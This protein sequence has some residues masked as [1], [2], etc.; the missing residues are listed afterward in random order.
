MEPRPGM[1]KACGIT[2]VE[3]ALAAA[4][5]GFDAVGM[6]FAESPRRVNPRLARE[7]CSALPPSVLRVGVF[8][9]Q[10]PGV[11]R[12]LMQFCGLDLAQLHEAGGTAVREILG[13]RAIVVLRPREIGD[14]EELENS[15]GLF[16]TLIDAWHPS[17]A[18]GTGLV[19]DWGLA[20]EAARRARIILAGGL[21]PGNVAEAI[22]RVRP[23][24]VDVCSGVEAEPGVK[25]PS[26]LRD[27]ARAARE[28]FRA[29]AVDPGVESPEEG[30][31]F[32]RKSSG[33]E[34][35]RRL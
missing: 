35:G 3:D 27:F 14:L 1:I 33:E 4:E 21:D 26:L 24:G 25:D 32:R 31:V 34:N 23:F 17:L 29:L 11:V 10:G 20:A 13:S 6:I 12:G 16:A 5:A 8:L 30:A 18:G 28:A 7:I 19:G 22:A 15:R 2:R 9:G